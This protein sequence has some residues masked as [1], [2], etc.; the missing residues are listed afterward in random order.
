MRQEAFAKPAVAIVDG[1]RNAR[2]GKHFV[3]RV[4]P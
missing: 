2:F 1:A 3:H 4:E